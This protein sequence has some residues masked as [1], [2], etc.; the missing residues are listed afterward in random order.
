[1]TPREVGGAIDRAEKVYFYVYLGDG[2]ED[3][4]D[5]NDE[6]I[7]LPDGSPVQE[8]N[9]QGEYIAIT[10]TLARKA[11]NAA[12]EKGVEE[13]EAYVDGNSLYIGE[14]LD[15]EEGAEEDGAEEDG[16]EIADEEEEEGVEEEDGGEEPE[17]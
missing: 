12:K 13:M 16:E 7:R 2:L 14:L 6:V 10:K 4:Y 15:D 11:A 5:D 17:A 3:T 9:I 1:M 8:M